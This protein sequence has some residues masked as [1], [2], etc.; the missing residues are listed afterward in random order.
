MGDSNG[1]GTHRGT[2]YR[3]SALATAFM[4]Q[5]SSVGPSRHPSGSLAGFFRAL[6]RLSTAEHRICKTECEYRSNGS[7]SLWAKPHQSLARRRSHARGALGDGLGFGLGARQG[8]AKSPLLIG[9]V[10]LYLV[11]VVTTGSD[12]MAGRFLTS[13]AYVSML[14][15]TLGASYRGFNKG[16]YFL[17]ATLAT[18]I[19]L[20]LPFSPLADDKRS[21]TISF[22][23]P[24]VVN[25]R[26][27]HQNALGAWNNLHGASW[28]THPFYV[29]ATTAKSSHER[30]LVHGALGLIGMATGLEPHIIDP[31]G[32]TDALLARIPFEPQFGYWRPGHLGRAIPSGYVESWVSGKNQLIDRCLRDYW[33]HLRIITTGS[34]FTL[35]RWR[36]IAKLNRQENATVHACPSVL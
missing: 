22:P 1:L 26:N 17:G 31:Q 28:R 35:P 7:H 6:L 15:V 36:A 19:I 10:L 27:F 12:Y 16:P 21:R 5:R 9:G 2:L 23:P 34:L 25:E 20:L 8:R 11:Y 29:A 24:P 30:V 33:G 13:T 3:L 32:L 18:G 14:L 4:A